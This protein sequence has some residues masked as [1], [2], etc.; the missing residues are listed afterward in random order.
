MTKF[1]QRMAFM[2]AVWVSAGTSH[3]API[4]FEEPVNNLT[5]SLAPWAP[6]FGHGDEFYQAGFWLDPFSNA[7]G[8]QAGDLVGALVDG[9]DIANT[10]WSVQCPANNTTTFY[11]S[12]NDGVLALGRLDG[13]A[14]TVNGFDASF[15]GA[16]GAILPAVSGLLRL[17]GLKADGS[18]FLTQTYQLSGPDASGAL[19]FSSYLTT[20]LFKDTDFDLLY[21]FGF[22]CNALG[23]C[24]AFSTDQAQFALDNLDLRLIP[25]PASW[26]LLAL[27]LA[28]LGAL[29]RRR[30]RAV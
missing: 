20:G 19:N 5:T 1:L 22:S 21:V 24:S 15:L 3:A 17:Q 29:T 13:R 7:P 6:L 23:S 27:G 9:T 14:F 4:T 10:C 8:A 28:G 16:S 12:L 26:V 25:E 11:T 30:R 2:A 18:G